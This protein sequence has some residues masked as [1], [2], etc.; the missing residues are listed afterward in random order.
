VKQAGRRAC[1]AA[2]HTFSTAK[3]KTRRWERRVL[4]LVVIGVYGFKYA[5]WLPR[6]LPSGDAHVGFI[7]CSRISLL[8]LL[9]SCSSV[10]IPNLTEPFAISH[11]FLLVCALT[12][13]WVGTAR[14]KQE[15]CHPKIP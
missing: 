8:V 7:V 13:P 9:F 14:R 2:D 4:S 15:V 5:A 11:R 3:R 6:I 12:S 1:A 10:W